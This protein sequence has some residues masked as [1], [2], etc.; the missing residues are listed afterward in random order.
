MQ[1]GILIV[2]FGTTYH[3]T[4]EKNIDKMVQTVREKYPQCLV[5]SAFSSEIVRKVLR[6]RDQIYIPNVKE[7][8]R[9]MAEKGVRKVTVFPTHIIDGIENHKMKQEVDTCRPLFEIVQIAD[10]LLTEEEDYERTADALWNAVADVAG[11]APVIFMG[12]GSE[13]EADESY[14]YLE[15]K[16]RKR[17]LNAV[18]LATV[19]GKVR[20]TDIIKRLQASSYKTGRVLVTPFM[21]VAGDHAENDMAGEEDSFASK[22]KDAGYTPE[23]LLKGIGEYEAVREIYFSHLIR[24]EKNG[25]FGKDREE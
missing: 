1:E 7:A 3:E 9:E 12:H 6:K 24:A 17:A 13:H 18:Y 11:S 25:L 21:F 15:A 22:L 5:L 4:R 23:C 10:A 2:S 8:L 14:G 19:E 16:L 20:I